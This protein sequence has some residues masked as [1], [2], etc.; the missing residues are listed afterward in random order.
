MSACKS[1]WLSL[2]LLA[3]AP[4]VAQERLAPW[5]LGV[6]GGLVLTGGERA[7]DDGRLYGFELGANLTQRWSVEAE[8]FAD[9]IEFDAGFD[10]DR[11]GL[12]FNLIQVNRVPLWNP[13][14]LVGL[15]ALRYEAPGESDTGLLAQIG[16]G[17]MWSLGSRAML[18]AEARYRY[19]RSDSAT[20]G[21]L[22]ETEPVLSVGLL[23][24][25]RW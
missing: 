8:W 18:R 21:L 7:A 9:T 1:W 16:V 10:L 17:G 24:P 22:D 25:F 4:A 6:K 11:Q 19:S 5:Y 20:P 12:A 15:G 13:Y 23:I 2:A 14:F 3:A